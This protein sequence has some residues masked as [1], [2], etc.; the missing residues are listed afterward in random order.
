MLLRRLGSAPSTGQA[1]ATGCTLALAAVA[2][3]H[4]PPEPIP[5]AP[6]TP[7]CAAESEAHPKLDAARSLWQRAAR[8]RERGEAAVAAELLQCARGVLERVTGA[9]ATLDAFQAPEPAAWSDGVAYWV[10]VSAAS[11]ETYVV[12]TSVEARGS[13]LTPLFALKGEP[14]DRFA[15]R[16][17]QLLLRDDEALLLYRD[18]ASTPV[19]FAGNDAIFAPDGRLVVFGTQQLDVVD[20]ATLSSR[21]ISTG[22]EVAARGEFVD[23]GRRFVSFTGGTACASE[24]PSGLAVVDLDAGQVLL[25]A[26]A[27]VSELSASRHYAAALT[28]ELVGTVTHRL[29]R[30]WDLQALAQPPTR[31]DV[32]EW[33]GTPSALQ[34]DAAEKRVFVSDCGVAGAGRFEGFT[35]RAAID[36]GDG[37]RRGAPA[38]ATIPP[39]DAT[40]VWERLSASYASLAAPQQLVTTERGP[41][42]FESFAKTPDGNLVALLAGNVTASEVQSVSQPVVLLVDV[43]SG[44]LKHRVTLPI[45]DARASFRGGKLEFA[46]TGA[47]LLVCL[48]A[49]TTHSVIVNVASQTAT[50]V[51]VPRPACDWSFS[52]DAVALLASEA[53]WDVAGRRSF[54]L[55]FVPAND[56][57]VDS[58]LTEPAPEASPAPPWLVCRAGAV[59]APA[60]VCFA[61]QTPALSR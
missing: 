61:P 35:T 49:D 24:S 37:T 26:P 53:A 33:S 43:R 11:H 29:L 7:G 5:R 31:A 51:D 13:A 21:T 38:A 57:S 34:F 52:A 59:L 16:A 42:R 30:I 15:Q 27:D 56:D 45:A 44:Q 23:G 19:R 20:V 6:P 9:T 46:S 47:H 1:L 41:G 12:Q 50:L 32:G 2:A 60:D 8:A 25:A 10:A 3:C 18:R 55:P 28:S 40:E 48:E 4:T 17:D 22:V 39:R 14:L 58:W 36:V 54:R